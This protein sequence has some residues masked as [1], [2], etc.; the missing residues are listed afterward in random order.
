VKKIIDELVN[1][2]TDLQPQVL[3]DLISRMVQLGGYRILRTRHFNSKGGDA[4]VVAEAE[5]SPLATAFEQQ[6]ILLIQVKKKT[7]ID[8]DDV[9]A[10]DQLVQ[11]ADIY[12]GAT[13]VV[14]STAE[15]FTEACL[16]AAKEN[17]VALNCRSNFSPI[18]AQVLLMRRDKYCERTLTFPSPA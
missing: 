13:P 9:K 14:I 15:R 5:L 8:N 3:E 16:S 7:G 18:A 17:H 10:V 1:R 11:M 4:D 2:L 6:S 12:P